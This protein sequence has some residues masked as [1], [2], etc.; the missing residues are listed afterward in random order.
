MMTYYDISDNAVFLKKTIAFL[1]KEL[2]IR[3][4]SESN[5]Q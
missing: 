3:G 4:K 5:S 1:K 2:Y